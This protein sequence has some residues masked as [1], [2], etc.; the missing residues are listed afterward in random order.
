MAP[1]VRYFFLRS[2]P[3]VAPIATV[4]FV[5]T[6]RPPSEFVGRKEM[7]LGGAEGEFVG[8]SSR[9]VL[10]RQFP[11]ARIHLCNNKRV[12]AMTP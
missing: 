7:A 11:W 5:T 8:K 1:G 2:K 9:L 10:R 12:M 4:E 3:M 6:S